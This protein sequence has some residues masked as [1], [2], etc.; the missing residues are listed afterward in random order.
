MSALLCCAVREQ[1]E[2]IKFFMNVVESLYGVDFKELRNSPVVY[3]VN[4]AVS[5]T[6]VPSR[7]WAGGLIKYKQKLTWGIQ[8]PF[9]FKF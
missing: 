5:K 8:F 3:V 2:L 1:R 4:T 7:I 6:A 9:Y